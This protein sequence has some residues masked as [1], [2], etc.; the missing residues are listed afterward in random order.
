[1]KSAGTVKAGTTI[2][3]AGLDSGDEFGTSLA[4]M[5]D[6]DGDGVSKPWV[7]NAQSSCSCLLPR[8]AYVL[9]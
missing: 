2:E 3:I 5:G 7:S 9:L 8:E 6:L 4:T 1:M